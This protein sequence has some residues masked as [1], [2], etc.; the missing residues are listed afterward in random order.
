MTGR[1]RRRCSAPII[2]GVIAGDA[3]TVSAD[4]ATY[5][6]KNAGTDKLVTVS[7][8]ALNGADAANYVL[9]QTTASANVGTITARDRYGQP[10]TRHRQQDL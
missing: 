4:S 5:A 10:S 3:V 2:D 9:D 7:G 1:R 6:D 8:M